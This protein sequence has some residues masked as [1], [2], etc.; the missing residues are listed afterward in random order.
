MSMAR[1]RTKLWTCSKC[2]RRF[3]KSKQWHSCQAQSTSHHFRG[4]EARLKQT[5][6]TLIARLQALGPLRVDAVKSSINFASTY[7]FGGVSVRKDHL[8]LGFLSDDV[9]ENQRIVRTEKLGPK[10]VAHRVIL[11]SPSDVDDQLVSWL[12]RAYALQ[13]R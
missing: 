5:Y 6:E 8:R 9:I 13:A 2:G 12:A 1:R 3:A 10:K 4:K 7:H 11:S